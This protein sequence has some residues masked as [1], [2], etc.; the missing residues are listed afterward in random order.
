MRLDHVLGWVAA[1]LITV[2]AGCGGSGTT[3]NANPNG[4]VPPVADNL[5][6][7]AALG[8]LPD[9]KLAA[10]FG[11]EMAL[12]LPVQNGNFSTNAIVNAGSVQL[13]SGATEMS[14]ALYGL[15]VQYVVD[16]TNP[17]NIIRA[18]VP[19]IAPYEM[20]IT[21]QG[22]K[23]WFMLA[24]FRNGVWNIQPTAINA[25]DEAFT[26]GLAPNAANAAGT[27]WFALVT[28]GNENVTLTNI[29]MDYPSQDFANVPVEYHEYVEAADGTLLATDAFLPLDTDNALLPDPPY[30]VVL[31]RTPYSKDPLLFGP[32]SQLMGG[33]NVVMV[34]QYFRGRL[35]DT[36]AWPDSQG[37][38]TLF[39][40][41]AG[42]D[43]TDGMDTIE[44]LQDRQFYNGSMLLAGPSALGMSVYQEAATAG[45][46]IKGFYPLMASSDVGT[47]AAQRNGCFKRSNVEGWLSGQGFPLE[48][49]TEAEDVYINNDKAYWAAV[50]FTT[51]ASGVNAP[52]WHETGWFDVDVESTIDS[53]AAI[54]LSGGPQAVGN[55]WLVIGPWTHSNAMSRGNEIGSLAFPADSS[56]NDPS[57]MPAKWDAL[58]LNQWSFYVIGRTIGYTPP[59]NRVLTYFIGEEGNTAAPHNRWYELPNWPPEFTASTYYLAGDNT[60]AASEPSSGTIDVPIDPADSVPTLGGAVLPVVFDLTPIVPGPIDQ[61]PVSGHA[62]IRHCDAA[63]TGADLCFAGPVQATLYVS[64]HG[65]VDSDVMCKL[66][67]VYPGGGQEICIADNAVRLSRYLSDNELGALVEDQVYEVGLEIG[68]RA[69]VLGPGHQLRLEIATTNYPRFE[70]NPGDGNAFWDPVDPSGV[71]GTLTV[72]CGPDTPSQI[73]LPLYNPAS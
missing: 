38:E 64:V 34:V 50:D 20:R 42:P 22:G 39:R 48:L 49:L 53:W 35:T 68:Q 59:I 27:F 5:P 23:Y 16:N 73:A 2:L 62:G 30:P 70:R 17:E 8:S 26:I 69:W 15:T 58:A 12:N 60:L 24:D 29:E 52:G 32:L 71:T 45:A 18:P 3:G 28:Y 10:A 57:V 56:I 14:Y 54:N 61:R 51:K 9:V 44:W 31:F 11:D 4:V 47:W 19:Y 46:D 66:V 36:G 33:L 25:G 37:T 21:T 6:A 40:E 1:V 67:D 43:H 41:H 72:H 7:V 13:P 63:A 55:Q 65:A